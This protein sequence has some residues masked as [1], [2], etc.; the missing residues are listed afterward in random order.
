MAVGHDNAAT[1]KLELER[2]SSLVDGEL[3]A[4]EAAQVLEALCR[5]AELQKRWSDLQLVGDAMR[6]T[7]VAACHVEGFCARVRRAL[8]DEPTVLAPRAHA[9]ARRYAVPGIAVAASI[10][11]IA[12]VAVP[13][14]RAPAPEMTARKAPV[15]APA[16][17]AAAEAPAPQAAKAATAIANARALDPYF[18]AHRELTGGTPLPR[19]TAY[20]RTGTG[21]R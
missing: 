2:L 3:D 21:E 4:D 9:P 12:F 15:A 20:L 10:A 6:S 14:L 5:D 1:G 17:V 11:A 18:A 19:A 8:A 13:L 16:A 7:E